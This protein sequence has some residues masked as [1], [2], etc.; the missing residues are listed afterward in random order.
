M[1]K[2]LLIG[3]DN[4]VNIIPQKAKPYYLRS[5]QKNIGIVFSKGGKN[6]NA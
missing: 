3:T 6:R 2:K 5:C 1:T 4:I